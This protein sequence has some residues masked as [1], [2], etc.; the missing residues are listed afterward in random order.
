M[1]SRQKNTGCIAAV[2]R[3]PAQEIGQA[4]KVQSHNVIVSLAGVELDGKSPW[5][6]RL[7]GELSAQSHSRE[8]D[9]DWSSHASRPQEMR[10]QS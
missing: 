3:W 7:I 2:S 10:L 4:Y 9:K 5:I 1:G 8:A 6:S